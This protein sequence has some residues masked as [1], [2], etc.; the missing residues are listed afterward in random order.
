MECH[1]FSFSNNNYCCVIRHQPNAICILCLSFTVNS[2]SKQRMVH[3]IDLSHAYATQ[4]ISNKL[5]K[6]KRFCCDKL[7]GTSDRDGRYGHGHIHCMYHIFVQNN[8]VYSFKNVAG[9][10]FCSEFLITP[11]QRRSCIGLDKHHLG[12][13]ISSIK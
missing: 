2:H 11:A 13:I 10:C 12:C 6:R 3:A 1:S 8:Y 9:C 5:N 7:H 4:A